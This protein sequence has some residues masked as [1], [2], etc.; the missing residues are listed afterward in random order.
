MLND[1]KGFLSVSEI[2]S[3]INNNPDSAFKTP[4]DYLWTL[5]QGSSIDERLNMTET[6]TFNDLLVESSKSYGG[7]QYEVIDGMLNTINDI[8]EARN[9]AFQTKWSEDEYDLKQKEF[10][11][12][13]V[14]ALSTL[15]KHL[16]DPEKVRRAISRLENEQNRDGGRQASYR[17]KALLLL[18]IYCVYCVNNKP[19]YK[20]NLRALFNSAKPIA[21]LVRCEDR[22]AKYSLYD[23]FYYVKKEA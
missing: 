2:K 22:K 23:R 9:D 1:K 19:N 21:N 4:M 20:D 7:S 13:I 15:S 5:I 11:Q 8:C 14:S 10:Q 17:R 6:K 3:Y 12:I 18:Y 16:A